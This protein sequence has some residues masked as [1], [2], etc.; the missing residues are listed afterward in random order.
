MGYDGIRGWL[1]CY[2]YS[3]HNFSDCSDT[4]ELG[5]KRLYI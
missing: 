3:Q 1:M 5:T 2:F 4:I